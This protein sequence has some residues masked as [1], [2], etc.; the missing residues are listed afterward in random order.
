[1]N[2][3]QSSRL[4]TKWMLTLL[5]FWIYLAL[6]ATESQ[7]VITAS[8][9]VTPTYPGGNPDPWNTGDELIV[10]DGSNGSLSIIGG[11]DVISSGG[12]QGFSP[13]TNGTI[14]VSGAGSTWTNSANLR[15]GA[16][17]KGTLNVL[18]GG[19]VD[20]QDASV[21]HLGGM[22][23]VLVSGAGSQWANAANLLV[24]NIGNGKVQIEQ[25][26]LVSSGTTILGVNVSAVGTIVVDGE[27]SRLQ[28]ASLQLGTPSDGGA[29]TVTLSGAGSRLYVG[30]A[31]VAQNSVLPLAET[32][33][34]VSK[35]G[36]AASVSIYDGN[37]L[38]NSGSAY[39]GVGA[40]ESGSVLVHGSGSSWSNGGNVFVGV[41]GTGNVTLA[42]GGQVSAVGTVSIGIG[43]KL[44]GQGSVIGVLTNS[45]DVAPNR[46][47][48]ALSVTGNY[49]QSASGELQIELAGTAASQFSNLTSTA[50]ATLAGTLTVDLGLNGGSPFEPQMGNSFSILS[51]AGGITGK[52]AAADLPNLVAG[53]MWQVR[54]TATAA[55]LVVTLAGDYNDDG[56]VNAADYTVWRN[57]SGATLDP[58][59]DGDTNGVVNIADYNIWKANF[60]A[61]AG[62]GSAELM[63]GSSVPEPGAAAI[64]LTMLAILSACTPMRRR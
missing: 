43:G 25:Q 28:V 14:T 40:G 13:L 19:H 11:S 32:A 51:A 36:T 59:A 56:F 31:A 20:D 50:Q 58:R 42:E 16:F 26:G 7:A 17:G 57:L 18:A 52:F 60:G 49:T 46:G 30:A 9:N 27:Q 3:R 21:G 55:N 38:A 6:G 63:L 44:S 47:A 33:M 54:Y 5:I 61:V 2:R 29:A 12:T 22:G 24:G 45:G 35:T 62:A 15:I 64:W 23:E 1:M 37:Q 53:R 48:A 10:A 41:D 4:A 39:L 8:G 34:V